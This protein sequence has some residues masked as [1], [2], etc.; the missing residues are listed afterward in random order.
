MHFPCLIEVVNSAT[1]FSGPGQ[2]IKAS[3]INPRLR[4]FGIS[5]SSLVDLDGNGVRDFAVGNKLIGIF[6]LAEV[7]YIDLLKVRIYPATR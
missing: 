6:S 2:V 7:T 3:D 1:L 5:F 4:G